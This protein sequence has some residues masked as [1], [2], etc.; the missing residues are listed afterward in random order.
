MG[1]VTVSQGCF[2]MTRTYLGIAPYSCIAGMLITLNNKNPKMSSGFTISIFILNSS[3]YSDYAILFLELI[4]MG[5]TC[6]TLIIGGR[7]LCGRQDSPGAINYNWLVPRQDLSTQTLNE[8]NHN[9][10]ECFQWSQKFRTKKKMAHWTGWKP[11][12]TSSWRAKALL[13]IDLPKRRD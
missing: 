9:E 12:T 7:D 1:T 4:G 13:P 10:W 5:Y 8:R 11:V 2:S 6:I 3:H